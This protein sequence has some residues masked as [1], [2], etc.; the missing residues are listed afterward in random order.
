MTDNIYKQIEGAT[1]DIIFKPPARKRTGISNYLF[2]GWLGTLFIF[3]FSIF[4]ANGNFTNTPPMLMGIFLISI[5]LGI[6]LFLG[7]CVF[8]LLDRNWL[9]LILSIFICLLF[10]LVLFSLPNG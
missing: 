10:F 7:I 6:G 1:D 8:V 4:V 5:A 3:Y 2:L 9:V